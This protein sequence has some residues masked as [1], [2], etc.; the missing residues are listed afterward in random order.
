M[1]LENRSKD[2]DVLE[3]KTAQAEETAP[4]SGELRADLM[5]LFRLLLK[6]P[7]KEHDIRNCPICKRFHITEI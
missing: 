3:E 5:A 7:P 6:Q 2:D 1:R 4:A